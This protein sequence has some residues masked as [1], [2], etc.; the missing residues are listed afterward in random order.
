MDTQQ[1]TLELE[2]ERSGSKLKVTAHW[3]GE[4]AHM[5]TLDPA[6]ESHR[7]RFIKVLCDKLPQ[8]DAQE[9]D[10]E[11]MGIADAMNTQPASP[12]TGNPNELLNA[13]PADVRHQAEAMLVDRELVDLILA[14][15]A[16]CGVV[17]EREL[18]LTVYVIGTSR[19]LLRPLAGI[20]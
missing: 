11:L 18:A 8:A 17:G 3:R 6:T 5:D 2:H 10:A 16:A 20:I 9:L 4:V 12:A 13:M 15:V 14:D 7:K 19:L 1:D